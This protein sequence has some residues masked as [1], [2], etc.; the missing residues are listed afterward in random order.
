MR[1]EHGVSHFP[2]LRGFGGALAPGGG[3]GSGCAVDS[4]LGLMDVTGRG[5]DWKRGCQEVNVGFS[6]DRIFETQQ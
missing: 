4:G 5:G 6:M 2:P 3:V 1:L